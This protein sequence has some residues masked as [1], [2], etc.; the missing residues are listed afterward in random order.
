MVS[1]SLY[2]QKPPQVLEK[3][4]DA[5]I[6]QSPNDG[7]TYVPERTTLIVRPYPSFV[8]GR[9]EKDFSFDVHGESSGTHSGKVLISDDNETL[10]FKPYQP[11]ALNERVNVTLSISGMENTVPVSYNFRITSI[12]E[13]EQIQR[14]RLFR[15]SEETENTKYVSRRI[16]TNPNDTIIKSKFIVDTLVP[17]KIAP[18]DIFTTINGSNGAF[19][20][21]LDNQALPIYRHQLFNPPCE[22]FRPWQNKFYSYIYSGQ[23]FLLDSNHNPIDTFMCGNGYQTYDH[24]FQL[25][26]NG[27]VLLMANESRDTDMRVITGDSTATTHGTVIGGIIQELDTKKVVVFQWRT[28]DHFQDTDV[29]H[30]NFHN[31]NLRT[32]DYCHLNSLEQDTDGNIIAS[33]RNMDEVTKIN[34]TTGKIIWR[35]GGKNSFFT[36]GGSD[37]IPF[38]YQHDVRRIG[39]GHITMMDNGNYHTTMWGDGSIHDTAWSRAIEY[40]LDES[41]LRATPVWEYS[42][43]DFTYAAGNVQ[44]LPNGNTFI[45]SGDFGLEKAIEVTSEGEKVFQLSFPIGEFTLR[46]YRFPPPPSSSTVVRLPGTARSFELQ[47]IYPNPAQNRAT[48]AFSLQ[49]KGDVQIDL[50]DVLGHTV[51][52]IQE[53]LSGAGAYSA[54][55]DLHKLTAGIYYCKLSVNGN[56]TMKMVVVEK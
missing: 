5:I 22:D 49:T 1:S 18:G 10:V 21:T 28:W 26:P 36:F 34:R 8:R 38:S 47:S 44:R 48:V 54:D 46:M 40:D 50:L 37:K 39:N 55:L 56:S 20:E 4:N 13:Q 15:E 43:I 51:L 52:Q 25:L 27:H 3:Q 35:W 12:S 19:L 24:E 14:L 6:Y 11:F 42:N 16:H 9:S 41:S 29:V 23:V 30:E 31:P 17:A 32:L 53:K 45:C 7:D 2:A 33:F